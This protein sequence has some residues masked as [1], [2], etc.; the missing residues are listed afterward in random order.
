[1]STYRLVI[2]GDFS[3]CLLADLQKRFLLYLIYGNNAL[4]K[5]SY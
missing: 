5:S 2:E 4:D 3:K 1:M